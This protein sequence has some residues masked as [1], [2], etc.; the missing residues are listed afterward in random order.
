MNQ[1]VVKTE[2]N[3]GCRT[4]H[5][6]IQIEIYNEEIKR[7]PGVSKFNNLLLNHTDF[8]DKMRKN[9]IEMKNKLQGMDLDAIDNWEAVKIKVYEVCKKLTKNS[10]KKKN[11]TLQNLYKLQQIM[12]EEACTKNK[13][14]EHE[15]H[16][17]ETESKITEIENEKTRASMFRSKCKYVKCGEKNTSYYFLH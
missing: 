14:N 10:T 6:L 9:L 4:D 7:G 11:C 1:Q 16:V 2:I 5:S 3:Y 8:T 17:Q 15:G 13:T 12:Q